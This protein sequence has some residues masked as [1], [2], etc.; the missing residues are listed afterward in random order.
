MTTVQDPPAP[1]APVAPASRAPRD[2]SVRRRRSALVALAY[3]ASA[4][5]VAIA[6]AVLV[7]SVPILPLAL[8]LSW[9]LLLDVV[10][11]PTFRRLAFRNISRRRGEAAL[12]ILGALLGTAIITASFVVGDTIDDSLSDLARTQLGQV[13][14]AVLVT[15]LDGLGAVAQTV[16]EAELSG[17]DGTMRLVSTGAPVASTAREPLAEPSAVLTEIDFDE[18][19][20]FGDDPDNTGLQAA[21]PTPAPG[22]AVIN[23]DLADRLEVEEGDV[24]VASAFGT[25]VELTV[26]DVIPEIGLAGY[27]TIE[28]LGFGTDPASPIFVAPGTI[29]ELATSSTVDTASPPSGQVLVSNVGGV[30]DGADGTDDVSRQLE[31]ALE[32]TDGVEVMTPKADLLQ[33]AEDTGASIQELYS[34]IG[35]FSVIAG[36]LLLV[37]LFVMLAE[38]RKTELGMLRAVGFKRG[39]LSRSFALEGSVYAVV[40][41]VLGAGLGVFVA[42]V[43]TAMAAR[44]FAADGAAF[45]SRLSIQPASLLIGGVIGLTI[46]LVTA[47][48]TSIRIARLNIIAAIRDLPE[49]KVRGRS[50]RSLLLS[51][52]GI[53]LGSL[54]LFG[55]LG[56]DDPFGTLAGFPIVAFSA[57]PLLTRFLPRK[58]VVIGVS[59]ASLAWAIASFTLFP[60]AMRSTDIAVFVVMGVILV[61]AAVTIASQV[62]HLW[63]WLADRFSGAGRGLSA[64]LG[65]AY[66]V[67]RKFRTGML[68]GMY[69]IVIFTMTFMSVFTGIFTAQA[70]L[71]TKELSAGYDVF[72]DSNAGNPVTVDELEANENVTAVAPLLRAFPEFRTETEDGP[73]PVAGFDE[74]L[75]DE[76]API[77]N[78]R[79]PEFETDEAVFEA[80]LEDDSLIVVDDFFLG[81][82]NGP[83]DGVAAVGDVVTIENPATGEERELTVVGI[84]ASDFIF[85]GAYVGRPF[86][87]DFFGSQAAENRHYVRVV[88]GQDPDRV[89][90]LLAGEYMSNGVD[91]NSFRTEIEGELAETQGF[92]NIMRGYLALGLLIGI[93]GLGVVMVRA[94]RER[95]R[96]IGMLRAMGVRPRTIRRAFVLE[97]TFVALQGAVMGITLGLLTSY[98]VLVNS[99]TFG[100]QPLG[101]SVPWLAIAVIL[102]APLVASLIAVAAPA[103]QASRILPAEALRIAD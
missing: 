12:V 9:P 69:A 21:G 56:S 61:T 76:R 37:N 82:G 31:D 53:L 83:P 28:T 48:A 34:G 89:A 41:S 36:V 100:D 15:G 39:H 33:D 13:D 101:F 22:D 90:T 103:T 71:F 63:V 30:F 50:L 49:S 91:A 85:N 70:P 11:K 94:V 29:E 1:V 40:A 88:D 46:A 35:S 8:L 52:A 38:E 93:A 17:T 10:L 58:G 3:V 87:E 4:V 62:D 84:H 6:G 18:A 81:D 24:I 47:W 102:V 65:L 26:R 55:A 5:V 51:V 25:G 96:E 64:R 27:G 44:N 60:D 19:R 14:E 78:R 59:L 86:V 75:L 23:H 80:L 74:S 95:R 16:D 67:A 97:A 99:S 72:V 73:W 42:W 45:A 57:I 32:G 66:P 92:F 7:P 2:G 79:L 54:V 68:L 98:E 77:L 43:L 20:A